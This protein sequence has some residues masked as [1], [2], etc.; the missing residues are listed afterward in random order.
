MLDEILKEIGAISQEIAE[1]FEE[2]NEHY[3]GTDPKVNE[4]IKSLRKLGDD[5][6]LDPYIRWLTHVVVIIEARRSRDYISY[7]KTLNV[8]ARLSLWVNISM[9]SIASELSQLKQPTL[10]PLP[11]ANIEKISK[12]ET[13]LTKLNNEFRKYSPTLKKFKQALDHTEKT[14]RDNR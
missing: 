8:L 5:K 13:E 12:I 6:N 4:Y 10:K 11:E 14:L 1:E 3:K 2:E 9:I 7:L